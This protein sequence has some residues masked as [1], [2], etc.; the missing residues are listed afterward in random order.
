MTLT[1]ALEQGLGGSP[2]GPA[3]TGKTESVKSLGLQLG[4]FVLVFC[5][6]DTFDY[7]AMGRI[8][9]GLCQVGAWGCFDEF[10]RLEERILSAVSQQI[11]T[12]QS[13]LRSSLN[14]SVATVSLL[15]RT[16]SLNSSTGIF[17][18]MNPGYAGRSNLPDNLKKLF[19]SIAMTH[20]DRQLIA[21]VTFFAQ[22]FSSAPN[23]ANRIV[24]FFDACTQQMSAQAHYDFGLRALK[25][26][27]LTCGSIKRRKLAEVS[28]ESVNA[29]WEAE[30]VLQSLSATIAPKLVGQDADILVSISET[31]FPGVR[32]VTEDFTALRQAISHSALASHLIATDRW[33][34]KV[35]QIYQ[36]QSIHHGFMLVG[37]AATGKSASRKTLLAAMDSMDGVETI[38]YVIDAK[39]L[40]KEAL[41]GRLDTTTREWSD[42]LFTSILRKIV[43]NFRG[44]DS[45]RYWIVFDGDID[46][47][48]VENMNSMLDD[49]K[50]LT[51]PTGERL[52]LPDNVRLVFEVESLKYATLATVSRC[53]M[54][55]FD[56]QS[57][58]VDMQWQA[59]LE[60]FKS[61]ASDR[62]VDE[63]LGMQHRM[64]NLVVNCLSAN[65]QESK[66]QTVL[67]YA[68][69]LSH[70]MEFT[71]ARVLENLF[72]LLQSMCN[73]LVQW[74]LAHADFPLSDEQCAS[75]I[76]K[77]F[78]LS[79]LWG[80]GGD[81][82]TNERHELAAFLAE[83]FPEACIP[84][85]QSLVNLNAEL[86]SGT[87]VEWS[88]RVALVD[89]DPSAVDATDLVIPT[90]DTV[91][92]EDRL[93]SWL[94]QRKPVIL[95][96][97]PGSGKTMS[98]TKALN[99]LPHC[100]QIGLNFS[101]ASTPELIQRTL[102]QYCVYRKT[103]KGV[104]MLPKNE[105]QWLVM[106]CDEINLP[107]RDT[108]GTQR[109]ISFLR[110]LI[111][112][113]GFWRAADQTWVAIERIQFVGACNPPTDVG[114][115]P[116]SQRFLR[117]A[118]VLMVDYPQAESL[119][120]IYG[121]FVRAVLKFVPTLK[122]YSDAI[123]AAMISVFDQSRSHFT[124]SK[125][126][127][128]I[129]SPRELSR[130]MRGIAETLR[131]TE[132]MNLEGL[133]R[134]WAHEA[135]RL[136]AD[137]L[138][139]SEEHDWTVQ[140]IRRVAQTHF[141]NL[142]EHEALAAPILYSNWLSKEYRSVNVEEMRFY[143]KARLKTFCEE[144]VDT[145]LVLYDDAVDHVLRI[146]RVF[147]QSQGHLILIGVSGS[148]KVRKR[149]AKS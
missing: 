126:S 16:V 1:Q 41:Y 115:T 19:R 37:P 137:R 119:S 63:E 52:A 35:T 31:V 141:P 60:S 8:F 95:C 99:Q 24:P 33:I 98:L 123:T 92:N 62:S 49:N 129:Y 107:A 130:W 53:G 112:Q 102:E 74:N 128:Y 101:S 4:R 26:V 146:D 149:D 66:L 7:Q 134:I 108:Y 67:I 135:L 48:W 127:H 87:W 118:P 85:L 55:Y 91:R 42:G 5:C 59:F 71:T 64:R 58:T 17:I 79:L 77:Q 61:V 36:I 96:G 46:P 113:S 117:H 94:S 44:E 13:G 120:Q 27:L 20:P 69:K 40:S 56:E 6:D 80:F 93:Y 23:L 70:I 90:T 81:C 122:G 3:G 132:D 45:R 15:G 140:L 43:D 144:E 114:R 133:V 86:P 57:I 54:V 89:I 47:V 103:P 75:F 136:F 9:L 39:V 100:E 142:D 65:S 25:S 29:D 148:G 38:T 105:G 2:F 116:F 68:A 30:L 83:T 21:Q 121:T 84:A 145:A 131:I 51:L 12:I 143:I 76:G 72:G 50:L 22:G 124:T 106:F 73:D 109:I 28:A 138:V 11:Q 14:S 125:Q 78:V 110:Q 147:R 18:T 32:A 111:E 88:R 10:N 139:T 97:P 104:T 82:G 34:L